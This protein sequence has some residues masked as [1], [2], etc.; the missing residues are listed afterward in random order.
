MSAATSI[1]ETM[2]RARA[3]SLA[4]SVKQRGTITF[5]EGEVAAWGQRG[6]TLSQIVTATIDLAAAGEAQ[7]T[8]A[9]DG[10][11]TITWTGGEQ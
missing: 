5:M 1:A 11:S 6:W 7:L 9:P 10:A 3:A 4:A 2:R 8:T